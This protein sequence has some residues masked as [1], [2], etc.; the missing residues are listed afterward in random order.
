MVMIPGPSELQVRLASL[1]EIAAEER[2]AKGL[3]SYT[4]AAKQ[5]VNAIPTGTLSER[6]AA[7]I[8][9]CVLE[10]AGVVG[11]DHRDRVLAMVAREFASGDYVPGNPLAY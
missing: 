6:D 8:I 2:A 1:K 3:T 11:S 9:A 4:T 7:D 5:A 10:A